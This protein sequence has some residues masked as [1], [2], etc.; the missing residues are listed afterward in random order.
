M[1]ICDSI[2][3]V[4]HYINPIALSQEIH[5]IRK[6][7][8]MLY[9]IHTKKLGVKK[10]NKTTSKHRLCYK[11]TY[12]ISQSDELSWHCK[13]SKGMNKF[14]NWITLS[15]LVITHRI[16]LFN[17]SGKMETRNHGLKM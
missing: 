7:L 16:N 9:V 4:V 13:L 3:Y 1:R 6:K 14:E 2:I 11:Q 15:F 10:Q 12:H 17:E 8:Q 5:R